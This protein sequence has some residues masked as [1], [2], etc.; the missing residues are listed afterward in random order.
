[1]KDQVL[2]DWQDDQKRRAE[3][4]AATA[5]MTAVQ[6]G[7]SFSDAATVAGVTPHLSPLLTRSAS[8]PSVPAT[9]L[10]VMFSLKPH[11]ATMMET[12]DGFIVAQLA[13]IQKP[14]PAADKAGYEQAKVAVA[15]S[16]GGDVGKV[17]ADAL[18]A[19]S[20][21]QINQRNFDNVVQPR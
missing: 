9:L 14:D 1:V 5:M 21:P 10:R 16:I 19:Q 13:E 7:Q 3:N 20:N 18:R 2:A 11:E 12:P 8:D 15:R 17:F 6:G 4:V